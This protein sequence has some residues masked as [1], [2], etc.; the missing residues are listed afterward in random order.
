MS[1]RRLSLKLTAVALCALAVAA[2]D[3]TGETSPFELRSPLLSFE[4][5]PAK[6]PAAKAAPARL[7]ITGKYH[8]VDGLHV[9]ALKELRVMGDRHLALDLDEMPSCRLP[10]FGPRVDRSGECPESVVARGSITVATFFPGDRDIPTTS[11]L[12]LWKTG[13]EQGGVKLFAYAY[14][15]APVVA[16]LLIPVEIRRLPKG[17]FGWKAV[18]SVPKIAGGAGSIT[19]FTLTIRRKLLSATCRRYFQFKSVSVLADGSR[20]DETFVRRC[21]VTEADVRQ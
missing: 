19:D 1:R 17:R 7:A 14:L 8:R 13:R 15:T 11:R 5:L 3:A 10:G 20:L 2:G 4:V 21:S 12:T 18:A 16:E 9:S 6:L